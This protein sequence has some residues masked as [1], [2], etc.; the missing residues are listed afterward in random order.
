M[1]YIKLYEKG[2]TDDIVISILNKLDNEKRIYI[3]KAAKTSS[4]EDAQWY[5]GYIEG[6]D[7][8]INLIKKG[9]DDMG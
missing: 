8:S 3:E 4:Y 1:K 5:D 6:I 2:S 7:L 9:F